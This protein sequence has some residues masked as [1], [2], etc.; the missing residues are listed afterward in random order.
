MR[1]IIALIGFALALIAGAA[2]AFADKR[3][4]LLIGNSRY[5][6]VAA[7][8]N[9][10]NDAALLKAALLKAGFDDVRVALDVRRTEMLR[11]LNAFADAAADADIAVVYYSGHG[12]EMGGVNYLVPVDAKLASDLEV[13][14]ETVS[15][16][17][18]MQALDGA[19]RLK[20]VILD[21]CRTN[22]F[23]AAMRV[24]GGHKAIEKGLAPVEPAG[25]DMLIAYA[26]K[27]GTPA[28]DGRDANSP[29]AVALAKRL[30][31]P[32]DDVELAL[33]K[34]RDDVLAAT[35][36]RQEPYKYGSLGGS[37]I[38]LSKAASKPK[39]APSST[40]N[41]ETPPISVAIP[42]ANSPSGNS[43][44]ASQ[45][46]A[47]IGQ[48]KQVCGTVAGVKELSAGLFINIDNPYPNAAMTAVIWRENINKIGSLQLTD[49]IRVC[50]SGLVQSYRGKPQ[51][52]ISRR[53][54]I[55]P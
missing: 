43:I 10:R 51:I 44:L 27:A 28:E 41:A 53:E 11:V 47:Y 23:V 35:H 32:G 26:A 17:R 14:D 39:P 49:N 22:P 30:I 42:D 9:P 15:L 38:A 4:A 37:V 1:G 16:D 46:Q 25:S 29:F 33:R 13:L 3:V 52:E 31:A 12:L 55:V 34:V 8:D 50:I 40:P 7:L 48:N 20:L 19:K 5:A 54:Q 6:A 21:A 18:V 24:R 2:P 45:A 36:G